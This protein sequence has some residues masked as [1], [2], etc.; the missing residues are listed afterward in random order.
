M[1][2]GGTGTEYIYLY[3]RYRISPYIYW[4]KNKSITNDCA[5]MKCVGISI[6]IKNII[7]KKEARDFLYI[8]GIV[9]KNL[10]HE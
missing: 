9:Y 3:T 7:I 6:H 4:M 8:I 1:T 5:K 2:R 10:L